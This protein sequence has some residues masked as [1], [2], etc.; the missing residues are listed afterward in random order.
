VIPV[1]VRLLHVEAGPGAGPLERQLATVRASLAGRAADAFRVAGATDVAVVAG[2]PDDTPFGA[3][4][5]Q[6]A[7]G[8]PGGLVV[9]GSGGFALARPEDLRPF[10]ESAASSERVA[11]ANNRYSAD[12]VAIACAADL[13]SVPDLAGDNALPRWL[14][15]VAGYAVRDLRSRRRLQVDVDGAVDALLTGAGWPDDAATRIVRQRLAAVTA[16]ARD[17]RA[18]LVVAGRTSARTL[19]WVERRAAARVR[20]IV[21]ERGLRAAAAGARSDGAP[22]RRPPRSLL[23]VLLERDGP[24]ALGERL[25]ELGDAA[26][27]DSRVL[28]AHR[29]G[30]D[31]RGW[32]TLED[33]LASDL[34]LPD[35]VADPWL[36]ALTASAATAP[37]PVV[38]GGHT[39]V[40]P[41]LPLALGA[42]R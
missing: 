39:L 1:A 21:E 38:L 20:A 29:V 41:G 3:R 31:E 40:G 23:G 32:P 8:L 14:A 22:N 25:A 2:P 15:E 27:V 30:A 12:L 6:L 26:V 24:G 7:D 42:R 11:L 13:G 16:V 5:R 36:R 35:R 19:R 9:G 10:V 28:L 4:L 37:I 18:E 34:L 33:R 17:P